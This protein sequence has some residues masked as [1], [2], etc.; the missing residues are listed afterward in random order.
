MK[1]GRLRDLLAGLRKRLETLL[2]DLRAADKKVLKMVMTAQV[3]GI[4]NGYL[5]V[6]THTTKHVGPVTSVLIGVLFGTPVFWWYFRPSLRSRWSDVWGP[7]ILVG[8]A[9]GVNN[10]AFQYALRWVRIQVMEPLAFLFSAGIMLRR[11]VVRDVRNGNYSTVLLPVLAVL[12]IWGLVHDTAGGAAGGAFTDKVP[13]VHVL[14]QSIP[15]WALGMSVIILTSATYAFWNRQLET[16]SGE[17][18]GKVNTLSGIPAFAI[19][20]VGTWLMEGS[21]GGVTIG[22]WPYLLVCAGSGMLLS[23]LNGV[24]MV[25]AYKKGL[26]TSTTAML[27]P[28][29]TLLG[30][31][32]GMVV[33]QVAPGPLGLAAMGLIIIASCGAA[34]IQSRKAAGS[35]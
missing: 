18:K 10:V 16:L 19:L 21:W 9:L 20:A 12:G 7:S 35:D 26:R 3:A 32:L 14:D 25:N 34:M 11:E 13:H 6:A 4:A 22:D 23:R 15:D 27:L 28:L 8:I 29:R 33:A 5:L 17:L 1:K 2:G 24:V 31:S 30:T